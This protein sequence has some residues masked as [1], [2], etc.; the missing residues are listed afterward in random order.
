M[1]TTI[2]PCTGTH[3]EEQKEL[4]KDTTSGGPATLNSKMGQG[5]LCHT[6]QD[7]EQDISKFTVLEPQTPQV[8][9]VPTNPKHVLSSAVCRTSTQALGFRYT[10]VIQPQMTYMLQ[11][12]P[13]HWRQLQQLPKL[14]HQFYS[15][16]RAPHF[17]VSSSWQSFT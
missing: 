17:S 5:G 6:A 15:K 10:Y 2:A 16:Y 3:T 8:P 4:G 12:K 7:Q 14:L 13:I 1:K 9:T 11:R